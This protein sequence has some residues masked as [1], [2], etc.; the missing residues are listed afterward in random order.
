MPPFAR[1]GGAR[2]TGQSIREGADGPNVLTRSTSENP[3]LGR[4]AESAHF[5]HTAEYVSDLQL[6]LAQHVWLA[7]ERSESV[8]QRACSSTAH[9]RLTE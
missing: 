5:A 4:E 3:C 6:P 8:S 1:G 7:T 9:T 2:C